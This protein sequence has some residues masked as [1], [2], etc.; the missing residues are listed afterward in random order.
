MRLDPLRLRD[1][2]PRPL[3][4]WL[5]AQFTLL[6]R[7]PSPNA[8]NDEPEMNWR[9]FPTDEA[10]DHCLDLLAMCRNPR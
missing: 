10:T 7:R 6:V 5:F 8:S 3:V 2:L 9:D 4:E 1:R